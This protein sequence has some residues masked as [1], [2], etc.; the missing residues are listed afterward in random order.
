MKTR[1]RLVLLLL[2]TTSPASADDVEKMALAQVR[3]STEAALATGCI[4]LGQV[5]DDS[6]K[7]L[8][9]KI[10]RVGGNTGIVSFGIDRIHAQ[11]FRCASAVATPPAPNAA[12]NIPPPPPGL[13]PPPPPQLSR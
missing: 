6:V 4:Q 11:V 13:P 7:D 1:T 10:L 3:L 12:P 2:M 8:R 9:R 5:M